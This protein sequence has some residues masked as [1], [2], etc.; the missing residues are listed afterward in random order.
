MKVVVTRKIPGNG[1]KML[2]D[3]G[4]E[5]TVGEQDGPMERSKLLE[6]IKGADGVLGQLQ[7]KVNEEY[8]TAVGSQLKIVANFA[9]GFDN[10]D[11]PA[12]SSHN[13]IGTNT[14]DVLTEAVA[15]HAFALIMAITRR[16]V[17]AH[18]LALTQGSSF[19][20]EVMLGM[21]LKGKTL[22]VLGL[23]R[24]GSR[25]AEIGKAMGMN[26]IYYDVKQN[27]EFEQ[28]VGAEFK[29]TPDE[30]LSASDIVSVHVPLLDST[31]HLINAD[32]LKMMKPTSYL[33]NTSRGPVVDE[34]ALV[35]ALKN[36]TIAGAALDVGETEPKWAPGLVDLD[37]V[38]LTPHIASATT[39][40]RSAMG[41][42]A[43]ENIIEVL[44]GRPPKTPV[45]KS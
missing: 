42:L 39:E 16:I 1:V 45:K 3:A 33:I 20:P 30:L 35:E 29:A 9:V 14:P 23:G 41:E 7:D 31:R 4:F 6:T 26:V 37:N 15:E 32:R 38:V 2:Q 21:E 12:L 28:K 18:K 43:A 25:V 8:L 17:E 11:L 5:V 13:V 44:S 36:K 10:F 34:V 40:A 19:G 22:G 27:P 24:I